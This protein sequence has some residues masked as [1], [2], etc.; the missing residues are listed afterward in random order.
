LLLVGVVIVAV[1]ALA[2]LY[3][4]LAGSGDVVVVTVDGEEYARLPLYKDTELEIVSERGTNL[5]IIKDGEAYVSEAS[6]PDKICVSTG[7]ADELKSVVC[8]PNR[9]TVR[10][11]SE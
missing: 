6:C 2:L 4:F 9:V 10:V 5:L 1:A 3:I 8:L 7:K 11:E